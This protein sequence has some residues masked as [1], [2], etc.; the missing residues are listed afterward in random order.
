[1][2]IYD[3][4]DYREAIEAGHLNVEEDEVGMMLLD[5]L[6]GL[7]SV[8]ALGDDVDIRGGLEQVSQ[9]IAS[10][11]FVIDDEGGYRHDCRAEA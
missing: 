8:C 6:D 1:V 9:L 11:L 2:T 10:E 3:A 7:D 5:E 4:L